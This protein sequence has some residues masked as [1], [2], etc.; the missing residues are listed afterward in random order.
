[1]LRAYF[2]TSVYS[3]LDSRTDPADVAALRQA[4]RAGS[5][6]VHVSATNILEL[7]GEAETNRPAAI[8]KLQQA[9]HLVGFHHGLLKEPTDVF[10][11]AFKAYA[12]GSD[13][14]AVLLAEPERRR[15][16]GG[17]CDFIAGSPALDRMVSELLIDSGT[18]K[19]HWLFEMM[20]DQEGAI[21]SLRSKGID[22]RTPAPP[23]DV[24]WNM[25]AIERL[26]NSFA[27]YFGCAEGC[28]R[29][30]LQE[31]LHVRV[32]RLGLGVTLS[33]INTHLVGQAG[34]RRQPHRGDSY[35]VWHA[36]LAGTSDVFL[37]FDRRL[38]EHIQRIPDLNGFTVV[39]TVR[40]LLQLHE[41]PKARSR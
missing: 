2:D 4:L 1:M 36:I 30:G 35:D 16:V 19:D 24:F 32:I 8:L 12:D 13:S 40:E 18:T 41:Y 17:L 26:A 14:P 25:S 34:N 38:A 33:Q 31:L 10:S 28:R 20:K 7:F 27:D 39:R 37:T 15:V 22:E 21:A 29:R 11:E 23:F 6:L 3:E 9:R 5:I